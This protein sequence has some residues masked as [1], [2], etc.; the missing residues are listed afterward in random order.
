MSD[1][2]VLR[3]QALEAMKTACAQ[4]VACGVSTL[5]P[6]AGRVVVKRMN[7]G[8]LTVKVTTVF[9]SQTA[10]DVEVFD[11]SGSR[12]WKFSLEGEGAG[13]LRLIEFVKENGATS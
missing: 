13:Q 8:A 7:A 4:V 6:D 11:E 2:D 5:P 12:C 10:V 9:A 3:A 1:E